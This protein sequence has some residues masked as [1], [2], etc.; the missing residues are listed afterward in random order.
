MPRF[1]NAHSTPRKD[2]LNKRDVSTSITS[3][4]YASRPYGP[5]HEKRAHPGVPGRDIR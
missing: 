3:Q 2:H 1:Y 5:H 4:R